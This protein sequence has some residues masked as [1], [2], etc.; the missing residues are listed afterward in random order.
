[1]DP[2]NGNSQDPPSPVIEPQP[3]SSREAVEGE[4][5]RQTPT[6]D[7][8]WPYLGR[9]SSPAPIIPVTPLSLVKETESDAPPASATD[10][11]PATETIVVPPLPTETTGTHPA[12]AITIISPQTTAFPSPAI[13]AATNTKSP[14]PPPGSLIHELNVVAEVTKPPDDS[15]NV[16][17]RMEDSEAESDKDGE[18][19]SDKGIAFVR[20]IGAWSKPLHFTPPHTPSEPATPRL[21]ISE[22]VKSQIDS[23]WPSLGETSTNGQKQKKGKL[24]PVQAAPHLPVR[25]FPPPTLKE[26]GSLR[27]PWA[28]RMNQSSRN[29]YRAAVPTYRLD[30]TPQVTIPSKVLKLGPENNE[31][32]IIGQFHRWSSPPGGLIHAVLN[33]LWGRECKISC[34]KLGDS[35]FL[36]HIPHENTRKW[37]V[38]RGVWHIDDC[39]LFVA[40]W[41]PVNSLNT[42]EISTLPVWVTLKNIPDS[43][44]SRLGISH[45]ASGL[46]EPMLT[47]KP[48]LDPTNMGEAKIL[49]EVELDKPFPKHIA[50][51]DKQGN[52]FFVDVEYAWIHSACGRCGALGHKEKRC[53]LPPKPLEVQTAKEA[54]SANEEIPI[55]DIAKVLHNTPSALI[56]HLEPG[57]QSPS[58]R[59]LH[60]A[61]TESHD[62][63]SPEVLVSSPTQLHEVHT[64]PCS[65]NDIILPILA[66]ANA[67]PHQSQIMEDVPSQI[68]TLE[69][70]GTSKSEQHIGV[71][72]PLAHNHQQFHIEPEIPV[73]FERGDNDEVGETSSYLTRGGRSIK[74]TQKIQDMGWTKV[75]GR[76]KGRRGR[77]RGSQNH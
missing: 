63:P 58:S 69:S 1:M 55:V 19:D 33:R 12:S 5:L 74:P 14:P 23:F 9:W 53:L 25:K 35:S 32:Y 31:E 47:H 56:D 2:F 68:I 41:S 30:G 64:A 76:G 49:V 57:S 11:P 27:F 22:A 13:L 45:I 36:F 72:T 26:D 24:F 46:G 44:F 7:P 3:K 17:S 73:S 28:A 50:L 61:P 43:C 52:I 54:P 34:R 66:A 20:S 51:D 62:T 75:G 18:A 48:R 16:I 8:R 39:L 77:G 29:L 15:A 65:K 6:P 42:P 71:Y 67:V 37:V 70:S 40:P 59:Q 10:P 4:A 21:T 38:Q 60:E